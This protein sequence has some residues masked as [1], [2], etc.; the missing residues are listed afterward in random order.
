MVR[1]SR[2]ALI[3]LRSTGIVDLC[4][5]YSIPFGIVEQL[6]DIL[7]ASRLAFANSGKISAAEPL[8]GYSKELV[9]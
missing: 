2:R 4:L 1:I 9:K 8:P 7:P 3:T 6:D 5:N